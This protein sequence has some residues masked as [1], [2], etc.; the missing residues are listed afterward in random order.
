M[1]DLTL[2]LTCQPLSLGVI[3]LDLTSLYNHTNMLNMQCHSFC[4]LN[5]HTGADPGGGWEGG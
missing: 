2:T 5:T 1:L 4:C 3:V